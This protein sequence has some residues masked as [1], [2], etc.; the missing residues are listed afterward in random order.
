MGMYGSLSMVT[1]LTSNVFYVASRNDVNIAL[2]PEYTTRRHTTSLYYAHS[3]LRGHVFKS[4][5]PSDSSE[6]KA[7]RFEMS[8][9]IDNL[10]A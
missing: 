1:E 8:A 7:I 4:E 2:A 9:F 6:I 3:G 10:L 5:V